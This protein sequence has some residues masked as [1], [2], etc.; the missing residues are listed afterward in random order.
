MNDFIISISKQ[1]KKCI[2]NNWFLT[3]R[4]PDRFSEVQTGFCNLWNEG[5]VTVKK[6]TSTNPTEKV[7]Q[8]QT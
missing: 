7:Q 4:L 8:K 5:N 6:L 1:N 3:D 2:F